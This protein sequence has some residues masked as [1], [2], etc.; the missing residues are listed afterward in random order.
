MGRQAQN[1]PI[2]GLASML[3]YMGARIITLELDRL[4]VKHNMYGEPVWDKSR[5]IFTI[6]R[7]QVNLT[8]MVHDSTEMETPYELAPLVAKVM[9]VCDTTMLMD[10][11]T[12]MYGLDW[13]VRLEVDME[14]G[15]SADSYKKWD[16]TP[17]SW[18]DAIK[19]AHANALKIGNNTSDKKM[20]QAITPTKTVLK[21]MDEVTLDLSTY[22][23]K[24]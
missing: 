16:Y 4:W 12:K 22:K 17:S 14:L 3:G 1:S 8:M 5:G 10:Y 20:Q 18:E 7:P 13:N 19:H 11:C 6:E 2:Q 23:V 24:K 9:E 21:M 15:S